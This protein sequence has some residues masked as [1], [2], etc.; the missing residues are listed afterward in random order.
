MI[1]K[2]LFF[3]LFSGLILFFYNYTKE[4]KTESEKKFAIEDIGSIDKIFLSDRKGTNLTLVKKDKR[5]IVN[6][7]YNVRNDAISTLL[8]TVGELEVQRPVS[9]T[10]YNNVI[11]QLATTGVKVE[12]YY[13]N[14]VKTYTVGGSTNN[15]LGTYMLMQGAD[16]PYVVHIA[17]FNGF[18]SPRYG[19]QGY[20]LDITSWRD[21]TIFN[22]ESENIN[23]ISLQ[24]LR[25]PK[26]SFQ[27]L[28]NPFRILDYN[29]KTIKY[30]SNQIME[31]FSLFS[32]INC[33]KY[34]GFNV[35]ISSEK[36]LYKL[37]IKHNNKIDTLDVFSFSKR[38]D[39]K[40]QSEPNVERMYARLNGG[41]F[42]LI[43]KY[44]F[45]KVFISIDDLTINL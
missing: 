5:W 10:S 8:N 25:N 30:R 39:N 15:H 45:N 12:I 2:F 16:N 6:E 1:K 4:L 35:D 42:M 44:V 23:E 40:N 21:N 27:I 22:I 9:N 14:K 18:L 43:Q 24:N 26:Q 31:Y 13:K 38:N 19:I 17:G 20:E 3:F 11:T 33:E 37:T 28:T 29:E 41:E 32:N 7:L 34:K 36:Q